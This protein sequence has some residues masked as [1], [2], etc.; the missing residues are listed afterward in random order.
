[1]YYVKIDLNI[2]NVLRLHSVVNYSI[3]VR[4]ENINYLLT[5]IFPQEKPRLITLT[6]EN[7]RMKML[8][9]LNLK[10]LIIN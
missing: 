2:V 9:E 3:F 7:E 1:M 4:E 10:Y 6:E 8:L 5:Y